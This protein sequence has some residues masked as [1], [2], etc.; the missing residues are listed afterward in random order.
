MQAAGGRNKDGADENSRSLSPSHTSPDPDQENLED[1]EEPSQD[2]FTIPTPDRG[3][4]VAISPAH[5]PYKPPKTKKLHWAAT[6]TSWPVE[7]SAV[8]H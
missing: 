1:M 3:K 4:R 5:S 8:H 6:I 7:Y 2:A